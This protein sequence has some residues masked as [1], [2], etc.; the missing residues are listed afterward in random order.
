MNSQRLAPTLCAFFLAAAMH[1]Q[2]QPFF[3]G[4][5]QIDSCVVELPLSY[6]KKDKERY[7]QAARFLEDVELIHLSYDKKTKTARY[8]RC[9]WW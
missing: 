2:T 6:A 7:T 9:S 1:A 8:T 5:E 3:A 4:A